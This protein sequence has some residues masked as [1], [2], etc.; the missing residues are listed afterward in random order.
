MVGEGP[1]AR[2][3]RGGRPRRRR[4]GPGA[5]TAAGLGV[6]AR[7]RFAAFRI[8]FLGFAFRIV[9]H[10]L[11]D[12]SF[13]RTSV[14]PQR[15]PLAQLWHHRPAERLPR[16]YSFAELLKSINQLSPARKR[17]PLCAGR[18]LCWV[19]FSAR[20]SPSFQAGS[21]PSWLSWPWQPFGPRY[22]NMGAWMPGSLFQQPQ[23]D[24][25]RFLVPR[26]SSASRPGP[27]P[28]LRRSTSGDSRLRVSDFGLPS[29]LGFRPSDFPSRRAPVS[30]APETQDD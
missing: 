13:P 23:C 1:E 19:I 9:S 4:P 14:P 24:G 29:D 11:P 2:K 25:N 26:E 12:M 6:T 5:G 10:R 18:R 17:I 3:T 28:A 15:Q 8:V 22:G 16:A 21:A 27:S 20:C 7:L 30:A